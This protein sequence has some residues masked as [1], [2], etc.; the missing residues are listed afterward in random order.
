MICVPVATGG[1][2]AG[3]V[4]TSDDGRLDEDTEEFRGFSRTSL[5]VEGDMEGEICR[6]NGGDAPAEGCGD[7]ALGGERCRNAF[8]ART[9]RFVSSEALP[10][11][12]GL[13]KFK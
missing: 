8:R 2:G 9:W 5:E 13:E 12:N 3:R 11:L 6:D 10:A 4:G 1:F 7:C